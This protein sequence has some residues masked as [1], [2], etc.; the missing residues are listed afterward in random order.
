MGH[1]EWNP[2]VILTSNPDFARTAL[3]EAGWQGLRAV[4]EHRVYRAPLVP[5]GWIDE[6]PS[7]NRLIGLNWLFAV[8]YERGNTEDM[9]RAGRDFYGL[10]YH[11]RPTDAQLDRLL[12]SAP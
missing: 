7:A 1:S 6:P 4:R 9:R 10:F 5:F 8:L 2:D 12:S 3:A 11:V